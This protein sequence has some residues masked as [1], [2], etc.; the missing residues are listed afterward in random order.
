M[1]F[2]LV[3]AFMS[4]FQSVKSYRNA[5]VTYNDT[6]MVQVVSELVHEL[7]KER[8][9]SATFLNGGLELSEVQKQRELV[10]SK[11]AG[12]EKTFQSSSV[13]VEHKS[14]VLEDLKGFPLL[15][16]KVSA[17]SITSAEAIAGYTAFIE[18]ALAAQKSVADLADLSELGGDVRTV[19]VLE[20][21]KESAGRLRA[22][23]ASI[24][25]A[26]KP[27]GD[28]QLEKVIALKAGVELSLR[29][30][31]LHMAPE[32]LAR[33]DEFFKS[34][35]W[36]EIGEVFQGVIKL[37]DKGG[38]GRDPKVFFQT[39]TTVIDGLGVL[40]TDKVKETRTESLETKNQALRS[41]LFVL[42]FLAL[43][44]VILVVVI[45]II[46]RGITDSIQGAV[47]G[48]QGTV[49]QIS[50]FAGSA[51][52]A[53]SR[54]AAAAT[55]AASSVQQTAASVEE[56]TAMIQKNAE[57]SKNASDQSDTAKE[58]AT[59]GQQ[60]VTQ[61]SQAIA[62]INHSNDTIMRDTAEGNRR[63]A[64]IVKLINEIGEKTKVINDIVFQTKLLSFNA[65]VE[66]ARAGD[67][68][69]GFAVVA[70]E[71]GNLA[72]MSG[73]AAEEISK[74]LAHS[75]KEV[76]EIISSTTAKLDES[77]RG[78]KVKVDHGVEV[79][80]RCSEVLA[81]I[82][83]N[84]NSVSQTVGEISSASREQASGVAEIN[85]AMA[86]MDKV[87]NDNAASAAASVNIA[88]QLAA[89]ATELKVIIDGLQ[90]SVSGEG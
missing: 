37:A 25:A 86:E 66:A 50:T 1:P 84:V 89:Q 10:D 13:S 54:L 17:K 2:L 27:V 14:N 15:R 34:K 78:A 36:Q 60:V 57:N 69:K 85:K 38:F 71:V 23:I 55:E 3:L 22:N 42:L 19:A 59:Q 9:K 87:T 16:E 83:E 73:K 68:G 47:S 18:K 51:K 75:T 80:Q 88:D 4:L 53:G 77:F 76:E 6:G 58:R 20:V 56:I 30:P 67:A 64:D 63:T 12:L 32:L 81:S 74:L 82:V 35:N 24:L 46:V 39:V 45:R 41:L 79:A 62:E 21:S 43:M 90:R 5:S 44:T 70:E 26:D 33:I 28:A 11:S 65:S 49:S 7:Q 48:L 61:M 72:R 31:A 29:S 40:V 52:D 8:G